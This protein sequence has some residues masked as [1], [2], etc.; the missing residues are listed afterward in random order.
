MPDILT[1]Q[2]RPEV[3]G[4]DRPMSTLLLLTSALQPSAEVLPGLALLG[5]QVKILPAEGSALMDAPDA[6]LILVDGRQELAHARDLCRLLRTTGTDGPVVLIVTEGGLAVVAHDWGMDDVVLHTCGPAELE[7]RI[8]LSIGRL[9]A[10]RDD[11]EPDAHVIRTGEVVVDD[12][13]YTASVSGRTLELTFKEVE[14][15]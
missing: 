7:A 10:A 4:D 14:L 3:I 8:R 12:A 15:L 11:D 9:L 2:S 1:H 5:P 13:T 6:D